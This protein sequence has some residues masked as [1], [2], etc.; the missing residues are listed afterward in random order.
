MTVSDPIALFLE[1]R[2]R[3]RAAAEPWDA[4]SCALA[5]TDEAGRPS[6]RFVLAKEVDAEGFWFYTNYES[7]KG[8]EL[9]RRPE[10]ALAFHFDRITL[11]YRVEGTVVRAPAARSDAYFAS[12]P[13]VSQLGAWA[14]EQSQPLPDEDTLPARLRALEEK[15][16]GEVPRPPHW[17]G[18]C[19]RPARI[20]RWT[21]GAFRL[22][23]R[24]LFT[25]SD[26]RWISKEIQP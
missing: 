15:Y 24:Q 18:F 5:T 20:E 16:P 14:S 17:G 25:W 9:S 22:H 11:Q 23:R 3:A 10:A 4:A 13:R 6:V 12:R 8:Q 7:R 21:E 19:L 2:E 26:N 1:D